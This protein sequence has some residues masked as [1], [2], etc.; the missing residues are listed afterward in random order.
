M[1]AEGPPPRVLEDGLASGLAGPEGDALRDSLSAAGALWFAARARYVEDLVAKAV[2]DGIGQYVIL[3][4]GLDSFAYRRPELLTRLT[5]YEVDHP[6]TQAWKRA[7]LE[8]IGV[9][10]PPE[11]V[12]AP[13]DFER[14]ELGAQLQAVGFS[15]E[16]PAVFSWIAVSQY[17]A[18]DAVEATLAALARCAR[19]TR[20]V[21][22][23][24]VPRDLLDAADQAVF[25]S[26]SGH[27]AKV[28]EP[29]VSLFEPAEIDAILDR[30][31]FADVVHAGR[32]D[33]LRVYAE[34]S[35]DDLLS[36]GVQRLVTATVS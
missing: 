12:F 6:A 1:H 26:V 28:G 35:R 21:L 5:V 23:Y 18:R 14:Q 24:D 11:L 33:V 34:L 3:G 16:V 19:G 30:S 20:I 8:Q 13:V 17:L 4:A 25:D 36:R 32:D 2:E 27:A 7:R 9:Q 31:G 29:F 22:S 15:W 10:I